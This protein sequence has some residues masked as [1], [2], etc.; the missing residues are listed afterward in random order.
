MKKILFA[1]MA[2]ALLAGT[3]SCKKEMEGKYAPKEKINAVY[4]EET[5][6]YNGSIESH[7]AKYKSEEWTWVKDRLDKIVYFNQYTYPTGEGDEMETEYE[8]TNLQTFTY[9]D[10]GRLT[11]S[12]IFGMETYVATCEYDGKYLKTMTITEDRELLVSYQFNRE[13]GKITSFDLTLGEDYFEMD[14]KSAK[15]LERVSPLRFV[16][17]AKP[18]EEVMKATKCYAKRAVKVGSK[19]NA[20]LHFSME[21]NGDNV[22]KIATSFMGETLRYDFNYDEKH[23]PFYNLFEMANTLENGFMPFMPLSKNNVIGV[24]RTM[25]EGGDVETETIQYSYT[26]NSKDYPTSKKEEETYE[27]S[28]YE[29]TYFYEYK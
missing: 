19:A 9:D 2:F 20:I 13:G 10:D 5:Y 27:E 6:W 14:E 26:Y 18:A 12:E 24:A 29:C 15:Q 8:Q 11:K 25:S 17:D 23:N 3:S 21:W 16:L 22:S 1:V 4:T 7:E 28:K